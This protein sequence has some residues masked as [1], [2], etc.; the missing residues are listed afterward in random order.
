MATVRERLAGLD[1]RYLGRAVDLGR[2]AD[3]AVIVLGCYLS[4]AGSD[5]PSAWSPFPRPLAVAAGVAGSVALWWRRKHPL[6]VAFLNVAA[7]A[8]SNNPIPT[9][10]ALYS[11]GT[12]RGGRWVMAGLVVAGTCAFAVPEVVDAS[13]VGASPLL[14]GALL[15]LVP[16]ALGRFARTRND[17]VASLRERAEAAD[18]ERELRAEQ[19][20]LG[21][22]ARIAREM[23]D[24]LAHKV[25]LIALHA[26]ALEVTPDAG[27]DT[28]E[29]VASVIRTTAGN[30]LEEL[31]SV[32]GVLREG[33]APADARAAP[34]CLLD[35][36]RLVETS[37]AAGLPVR[38]EAGVDDLPPAAARAAYRVV[39]EALTNVHK[40]APGASTAVTL[41]GDRASGLTVTVANGPALVTGP[42]L[43]GSGSG[44]V[45]LDERVR[46][47]GGRLASGPE[48]DDPGGW[49]VEAWV[50]WTGI[51]DA[52]PHRA[53]EAASP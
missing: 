21:E 29:E 22:R 26:G 12:V 31:R 27:P 1:E 38:L 35:V 13:E 25:S 48:P 49:R 46:L 8:L 45:G 19:A 15:T 20:R 34:S 33:D 6:E 9:V 40:H 32:L 11:A 3:V 42:V 44:L 52:A 50:P 41:R 53:A 5:G 2:A 18:A 39:Q 28:V 10:V 51:P 47:L 37:R 24:V 7:V 14:A 16:L 36:A 43:P 30:A 4:V 23:H 17:L